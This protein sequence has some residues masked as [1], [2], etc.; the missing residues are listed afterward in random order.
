MILPRPAKKIV[1]RLI[2]KPSGRGPE[3][4]EAVCEEMLKKEAIDW[5]YI[6]L[7]VFTYLYLGALAIFFFANLKGT[8]PVLFVFLDALQEPY[9][10]AL[11]VYVVLKEIRKRRYSHPSRYLGEVFVIFWFLLLA[12]STIAVWIGAHTFDAAYKIIFTNSLAALIIFIG[13]RINKP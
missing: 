1:C 6:L 8:I 10:G 5:L 12:F 11:G 4:D 9:L 7:W 3:F 2:V 13:S